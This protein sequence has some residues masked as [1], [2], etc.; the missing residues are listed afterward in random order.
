MTLAEL[1]D[2]VDAA[3]DEAGGK[4]MAEYFSLTTG[5]FYYP[6]VSNVEISHHDYLGHDVAY[7][8]IIIQE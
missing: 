5:E 2:V 8:D 6:N 1:K 4:D 3:V 7:L